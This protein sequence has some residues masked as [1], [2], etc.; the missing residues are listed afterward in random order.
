MISRIIQVLF[1]LLITFFNFNAFFLASNVINQYRNNIL[2]SKTKLFISTESDIDIVSTSTSEAT[3]TSIS[4]TDVWW[5]EGLKFG[6]TACG[7]CCQNEGEVW[8]DS[9]EFSD[10]S[11]HLKE[12]PQTVLEKYSESVMSGTRMIC[13]IL[14]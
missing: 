1:I 14:H 3:S 12:S 5:K 2:N 10:L 6:C 4:T 11:I 9:D 13:E 7:R 8:L